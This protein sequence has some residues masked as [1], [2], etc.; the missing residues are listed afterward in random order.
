MKRQDNFVTDIIQGTG[1]E[2]GL[3][4]WQQAEGEMKEILEK[5]TKPNNLILDPFGGSGTTAISC[6]KNNRRCFIIEKEKEDFDKI[7]KRIKKWKSTG[8]N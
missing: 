2:K 1:S 8:E 3:H 4:E 5:F 6:L 7:N